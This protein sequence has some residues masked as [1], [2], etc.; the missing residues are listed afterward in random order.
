MPSPKSAIQSGRE[1]NAR[2]DG[3][4]VKKAL[5]IT[6]VALLA[7][8]LAIRANAV[9]VLFCE[10]LLAVFCDNLHVACAGRSSIPTVIFRVVFDAAGYLAEFGPNL[11]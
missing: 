6:T 1:S 7:A 2:S 3:E 9:E 5:R 11:A 8:S 10:P 4:S